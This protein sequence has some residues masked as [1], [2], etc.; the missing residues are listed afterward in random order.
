MTRTRSVL[1][2]LALGL[3]LLLGGCALDPEQPVRPAPRPAD[4]R[5][6]IVALL[7][8]T[9]TDRPG[10]AVDIYAAFAALRLD[11]SPANLCAV[12]AVTEQESTFRADPTVPGLAKIVWEEIDRRAEQAGVPRLLVHAALQLRAKDGRSYSERIDSAKTEKE[13]SELFVDFIG[14]VPLG[15]RLFAGYNP[16]RTGGPMQVSIDFAERHAK[17]KP[18]PYP[19]D[20]SIRD[21]VFTR[22]GGLYFGIAHLLDYP[23][24][25][26]ALIY[27]YADFNAG[28][29]ASRNAG[30]QNA[31]SK[32]SGIPLALDGDLVREGSDKPG[33]T[34][35]A[36][37]S[38]G[39][40]LDISDSAIRRALE[41]GDR[42]DFAQSR[43]YQRVFELAEQIERRPLPRAVIPNIRLQSPKI[44]RPLTTEWF[45]R[46]VDD[47]HKRCMA[48]ASAAPPPAQ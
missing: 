35:T 27:R 13:L 4:V 20:G 41:Q 47:R 39:P 46:R 1:A 10:W 38:L 9:V 5:A 37:R 43:L 7:P 8:T 44:T 32:A 48:R 25:Y 15:Q 23:V 45:A 14:S 40:R 42:A 28:R 6:Q 11:P 21:E 12:L 2:P 29:Y 18:Y 30:F 31:V 26:D 16:V 33:N 17:D 36:V 34:E 19:V 24:R 22:R 3:A